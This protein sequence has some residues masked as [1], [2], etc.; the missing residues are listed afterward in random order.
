[1]VPVVSLREPPVPRNF[2]LGPEPQIFPISPRT[3]VGPSQ[4]RFS[5]FLVL[6]ERPCQAS[7]VQQTL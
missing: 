6:Q 3:S 7:D 4:P 1:M 5:R 2:T